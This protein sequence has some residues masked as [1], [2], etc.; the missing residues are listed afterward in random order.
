MT[1]A[2]VLTNY[3]CNYQFCVN[4]YAFYKEGGEEEREKKYVKFN[5]FGPESGLLV[6]VGIGYL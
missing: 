5:V 3:L 4:N 2:E 6:A 1:I